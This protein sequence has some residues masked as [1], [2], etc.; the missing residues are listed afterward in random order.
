M[1]NKPRSNTM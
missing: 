1:E